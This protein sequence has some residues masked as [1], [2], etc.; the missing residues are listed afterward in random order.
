[1]KLVNIPFEGSTILFKRTRVGYRREYSVHLFLGQCSGSGLNEV[2]IKTSTGAADE[3]LLL[4][5]VLEVW[6]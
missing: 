3:E 2:P 5:V 1:M 6:Q 4:F